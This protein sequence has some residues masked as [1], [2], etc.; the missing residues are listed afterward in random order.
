M[1]WYCCRYYK[2]GLKEIEQEMGNDNQLIQ[3]VMT[4][5]HSASSLITIS[6]GILVHFRCGTKHCK[7]QNDSKV[8]STHSHT[9]KTTQIMSLITEEESEWR[10]KAKD[11][12]C[13]QMDWPGEEYLCNGENYFQLRS[14]EPFVTNR[15]KWMISVSSFRPSVHICIRNMFH[16]D[17]LCVSCFYPFRIPVFSFPFI[18]LFVPSAVAILTD[19]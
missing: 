1:D 17:S 16:C 11:R 12:C 18:Q 7:H 6:H 14:Q 15:T 9:F 2:A 8:N 13:W 4:P 5:C 10:N 19:T 3:W